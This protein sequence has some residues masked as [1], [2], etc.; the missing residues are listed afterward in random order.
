M[1]LDPQTLHFIPSQTPHPQP[2]VAVEIVSPL[3]KLLESIVP[4]TLNKLGYQF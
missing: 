1:I 2:S 4:Q 3:L